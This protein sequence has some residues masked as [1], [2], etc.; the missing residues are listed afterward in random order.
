MKVI[1]C[2]DCG[3]VMQKYASKCG[4]CGRQNLTWYHPDDKDLKDR[5]RQITGKREPSEPIVSLLVV[6]LVVSG[7]CGAYYG[8]Q[9]MFAPKQAPSIATTPGGGTR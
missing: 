9:V 1:L 2:G 8:W 4:R 5:I 3:T 7:V 6:A